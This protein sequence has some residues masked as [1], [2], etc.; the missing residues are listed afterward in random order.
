MKGFT[1]KLDVLL[2]K[3]KQITSPK[4]RVSEIP[5]FQKQQRLIGT[6]VRL[7]SMTSILLSSNTISFLN[8]EDCQCCIRASFSYKIAARN[9]KR[10]HAEEAMVKR[11]NR[12]K[13]GLP[14][15]ATTDQICPAGVSKHFGTIK[16]LMFP[17]QT[18][19]LP[20]WSA[21]AS[22]LKLSNN[23]YSFKPCLI[24]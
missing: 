13:R 8:A 14:Q 5:E 15:W 19:W 1:K 7:V 17:R 18:S 16:W 23:F 10:K 12:Q 3:K 20:V 11:E 24:K 22:R 4:R 6:I 21:F 2:K 9:R